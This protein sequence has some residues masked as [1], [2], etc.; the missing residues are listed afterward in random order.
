MALQ[1]LGKGGEELVNRTIET[2]EKAQVRH[3]TERAIQLAMASRWEEAVSANK[4]ILKLFPNDGDSYNRLGKAFMELNRYSDAK[5]AYKKALELD[6]SNQIARKNLS[7]LSALAKTGAA[8]VETS[9]V[10]PNVFIEEVGK[11]AVTT[12]ERVPPEAL[13]RLNGGDQVELRPQGSE[14]VVE[15]AAGELIG[16]MEPKLAHRLIKLMEGGNKYTAAVTALDADACQLIIK[17]TYRDPSQAGGP[18]LPAAIVTEA[19]RPYTKQSL[20][21]HDTRVESGAPADE[22]DDEA[23]DGSEDWQSERVLQEGHMSLNKAAAAEDADDEE[24][25]E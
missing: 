19:L 7:R 20:V 1:S 18:S 17:E 8:Q 23:K 10:D 22:P 4:A 6:A 15:T 16:T 2:A 14:L 11:T 25:E 21:H 9:P 13:A 12:L 5:K 3:Q 24:L